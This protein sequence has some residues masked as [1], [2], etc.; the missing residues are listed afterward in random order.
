MKKLVL[1]SDQIVNKT[2]EIDNELIKLVDNKEPKLAYIPSCSDLE[3]KYYNQKME[4][5]MR[6]GIRSFLYFDVDK[7]YDNEL[8]KE[9]LNCDVIHLS[10]GDPLD[11]LTNIK[12][13]KFDHLLR[14]YVEKGGVLVGVS[15]GAIIMSEFIDISAFR[16]DRKDKIIGNKGLNLV[17][18]DFMP[19][20][21]RGIYTLEELKKYSFQN[22]R[23]VYLCND[24]GGIIINDNNIKVIGEIV[25]IKNG[26]IID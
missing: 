26:C 20:W 11:F 17:D 1:Y 6:L 14:K 19:H 10:G 15:A 3:R 25:K 18:F 23:I 12:M 21:D 7:E 16:D 13:R 24:G 9:L 8:I 4:Y 5:Y 2:K 22:K